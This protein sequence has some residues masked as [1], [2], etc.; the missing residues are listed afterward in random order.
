MRLLLAVILHAVAAAL[1]AAQLTVASTS[2]LLNANNV[3]RTA[4]ISVTFDRALNTFT[5]SSAQFHAFGK[6]S[7]P[8][9]GALTFSNASRTLTL[10]PT[11][12]FY[13]GESVMV[14]ISH[15][16]RAADGSF[17]RAQGYS[18]TFTVGVTPTYH[19]FELFDS[20]SNRDNPEDITRIY[21]GLACDLNRDGRLDLST[22]N[23][24]SGDLRTFLHTGSY[25]T[26]YAAPVTPYPAIPLS[27]SPNDIA[28]FN[29]DG[30]ID[31]ITASDSEN[32]FAILRGNG[33]GTFQQGVDIE[34]GLY[35]RGIVT[36]DVDGDA[37]FDIAVAHYISG[38]V[39][40]LQ[41]NGVGIF[42]TQTDIAIPGGPWALATADMNNDGIMDLVVGAAGT[43]Q[44]IILRG[45]GN[46]SFTQV[47][48][49]P[50][51]GHS[52]VIQC[53]D[54][55][56]DRNIDITS[57]NSTSANGAILLGNG[58][59]TLQ[60][61]TT[62][63]T[64]GNTVSTDVADLDGDGDIDWVLSSFGAGVWYLYLNNGNGTF[65]PVEEFDAPRNPSCALAMDVD[66]DGDIDLALT[67]ELADEILLLRNQCVSIDFNNDALFPDTTDIAD[68]ITV[69]SGGA[70]ST[71]DCGSIDV[72]NDTLF[73]DTADI[74]AFL[75]V[76]AGGP[77]I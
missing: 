16:L 49:R 74:Q 51:G 58:N 48:S 61:A 53:A 30:L 13:A 68:L 70:C 22:I 11:R 6:Q 71:G 12:P 72:N 21:G 19:R 2:P 60:P 5:T 35:A 3:A 75:R 40:I 76:F 62:Y 50:V 46:G 55:N 18:F 29:R 9:A 37:D 20:F 36:L 63:T 17:L 57:A 14:L 31:F 1:A 32:K 38:T 8:I 42:A 27:S 54:L 7:G 66:N 33:D 44:V 43:Q 64:G 59:S 24:D 69:F 67:D 10:T 25:D 73:P 4:P 77:C 26:P 65:T 56:N 41:N 15:N 39:S 47:S 34:A 52:W 45:N 28:D 23:Q